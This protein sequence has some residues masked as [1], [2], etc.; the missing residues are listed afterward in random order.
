[1]FHYSSPLPVGNWGHYEVDIENMEG[2]KI[3]FKRNTERLPK[4]VVSVS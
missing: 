2:I 1:M 3:K 4:K